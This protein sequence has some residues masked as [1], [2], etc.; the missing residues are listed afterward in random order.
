MHSIKLMKNFDCI[1]AGN[2]AVGFA[3]GFELTKKSSKNFKLGI[4]GKKNKTGSASLAAGAMINIFA[5]IEF[6]TLNSIPGRTKFECLLSAKNDWP[7]Y[8]DD[9]KVLSKQKLN[10]HKGTFVINNSSANNLDDDNFNQIQKSLKKYKEKFYNVKNEDIPGYLPL[11]KYRSLRSIYIPNENFIPST[12]NFLESYEKFF[13]K[14]TKSDLIDEEIAT[15]KWKKESIKIISST[16]EMYSCKNL[17]IAAGSYSQNLINQLPKI[18][19]KIPKTYF[20]TGNALIIKSRKDHKIQNVIRTTN[21][22]LACGLHVV[23]L[24]KNHLYVGATN[25]ISTEEKNKPL[26]ST[27]QTMQNSL[28]REINNTLGDS[29]IIKICVGHRPTTLDTFPLIGKTSLN[30]VYI[31]TGNKRDGLTMSPYIGKKISEMIINDVKNNL[32]KIFKPERKLIVTMSKKEGI[33]KTCKHYISAALQ[34][35]LMLP[36]NETE[37]S[38]KEN[39]RNLVKNIY[40][41]ANLKFGVPPEMLNIYK[42]KKN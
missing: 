41:K 40:N 22:G 42:Y 4:F 31:A 33:E 20:G 30:N 21:R 19:K 24:N 7:K 17:V 9:L 27:I 3:I 35:D 29:E 15:I 23:P 10:L 25:R 28:L 26:I 18:S 1:I 11:S 34:H 39:I 8:I 36:N 5:E 13:E 12:K 14:N 2:G 16:G 37:N 38:Y 32:P 6:D